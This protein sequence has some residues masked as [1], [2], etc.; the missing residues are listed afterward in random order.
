MALFQ[1]FGEAGKG[2]QPGESKNE[3][4]E[5]SGNYH[6]ARFDTAATYLTVIQGMKKGLIPPGYFSKLLK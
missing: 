4:F 1:E 5:G 3:L 6:D 2:D